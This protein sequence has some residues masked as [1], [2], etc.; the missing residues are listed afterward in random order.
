MGDGWS[1]GRASAKTETLD[2]DESWG[3]SGGQQLEWV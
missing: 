2:K 1:Q 3:L